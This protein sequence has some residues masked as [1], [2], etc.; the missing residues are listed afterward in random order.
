MDQLRLETTTFHSDSLIASVGVDAIVGQLAVS[1]TELLIAEGKYPLHGLRLHDVDVTIALRDTPPD[2]TAQD[3]TPLRL[4]FDIPDGELRNIH[5]AMTPLNLDIRTRSL[6][7]NALVDV[8]A[9]IY[10]ARRLNVGGLTF[11]LSH[12]RIPT[13]TI[14]GSAFV[15][16]KSNRIASRGLHVRS[17]EIGAKADLQTTEM[18]LESMQVEVTGDAEFQGSKAQLRASYDIDDEFYDAQVH[19]ERVNLSPFLQNNTRIVL[20]GDVEARGKGIEPKRPMRSHVKLRL[21]EAIYD[22]YNL[23]HTTFE[24]TT[25]DVTSLSLAMP[26]FDAQ[27]HSPMPLFTLIDRIRPLMATVTDSTVIQSL[28]SL[29]D[30]S[31]LDTIRRNIPAISADIAL[32]KGSPIQAIIDSTGM[33]FSEVSLAFRSDSSKTSI[34]LPRFTFFLPASL[35]MP[36][37]EAAL[38]IGMTEGKTDI[39]LLANTHLTD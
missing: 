32:R 13:D 17:D 4:A 3:T 14:Y 26:G 23:S 6:S 11:G 22:R 39:S 8:G 24:G 38:C 10:D 33:D 12:L 19:I 30:L 31:V 35:S 1:S 2:T 27:I 18:N 25:D 21:D 36:A 5:Y 20:A 29:K 37:I 7:T 28:T 34:D 15:D 9:N 16:L